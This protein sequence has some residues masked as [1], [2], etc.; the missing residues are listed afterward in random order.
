MFSHHLKNELSVYS[1]PNVDTSLNDYVNDKHEYI[2]LF[3]VDVHIFC[4]FLSAT[5]PLPLAGL[6]G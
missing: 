3:P 4:C 5:I 1:D 2:I 6:E